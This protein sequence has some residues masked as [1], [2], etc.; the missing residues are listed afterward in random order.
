MAGHGGPPRE[1]GVRLDQAALH[2]LVEAGSV[3]R[4]VQEHDAL[5]HHQV[6]DAVHVEPDGVDG[7]DAVLSHHPSL[8]RPRKPMGDKGRTG[9]NRGPRRGAASALRGLGRCAPGDAPRQGRERERPGRRSEA[10]EHL[11]PQRRAAV[12]GK[13]DAVRAGGTDSAQSPDHSS[14]NPAYVEVTLRVVSVSF[15]KPACPRSCAISPSRPKRRVRASSGACGS[16][17]SAASQNAPQHLHAP[18]KSHTQAATVP[19]GRSTRRNSRAACAG[20]G[21]EVQHQLGQDTVEG[22]VLEREVLGLSRVDL[23]PRIARGALTDERR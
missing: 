2:H 14:S 13:A 11:R 23:D 21:H 18:S 17:A 7:V 19:P 20:I 3:D 1:D 10:V 9:M 22:A 6:L 16:I 15:S 5:D 12:L 8:S 4:P